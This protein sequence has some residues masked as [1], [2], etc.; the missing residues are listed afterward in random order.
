MQLFQDISL[1]ARGKKKP[2]RKQEP[3][4]N[5]HEKNLKEKAKPFLC[6]LLAINDT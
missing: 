4:N 5:L 6:C 3:R 1:S 2:Q